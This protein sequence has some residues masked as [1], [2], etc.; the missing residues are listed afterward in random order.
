MTPFWAQ[1]WAL[2]CARAQ[3]FSVRSR[4]PKRI[5]APLTL[6]LRPNERMLTKALVMEEVAWSRLLWTQIQ[7]R[8]ESFKTSPLRILDE[9]L[10]IRFKSSNNKQEQHKTKDPSGLDKYQYIISVP[11]LISIA[12]KYL[13]TP[14]KKKNRNWWHPC[15]HYE[16]S[17]YRLI[18]QKN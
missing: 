4:S 6:A 16:R 2:I 15:T 10:P 12:D 1:K 17:K 8:L 3:W 9:M 13:R 11:H 18:N 5:W 7:S 14:S